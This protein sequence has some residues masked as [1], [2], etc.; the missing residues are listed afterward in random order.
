MVRGRFHFSLRAVPILAALFALLVGV[1][2][3]SPPRLHAAS[4]PLVTTVEAPP[5]ADA[6]KA[7]GRVEPQIPSAPIGDRLSPLS[8]ALG[9]E[10][11]SASA[12]VGTLH[13]TTLDA[14]REGWR[15][16]L[17][18]PVP[19]MERGDPPRHEG[20]RPSCLLLG[21]S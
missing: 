14:R 18:K 4:L 6:L 15:A 17:L 11:L 21:L 12:L 16:S 5:P 19:R 1:Y 20:L 13:A 9:I 8:P 2:G 7:G 10:A 3:K